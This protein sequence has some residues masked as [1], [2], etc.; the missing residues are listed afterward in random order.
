[1][2]DFSLSITHW[3]RQN[4]RTLPWRSTSNPYF[5]W[6]SEIILQQ[7]RV[8]Q[9]M[10]YYLKFIQNYPDV[11]ALANAPEMEVL[12]DWQGLGYYSRARN[13]HYSAKLIVDQFNGEFPKTFEEILQ[14]KGV[15]KYTAAAIASFAYNE[16][17]A[18]VDGNVYR[19]LSRV[20]DI[21]T[22][23]DIRKG[24]LFFQELADTLIPDKNP[25]EHNQAMMEMGA[26]IC[27]PSPNCTAC[28]IDHLCLAKERG[29]ISIRPVKSKRI[30]VRNRYFIY[31]IYDNG[32]SIVVEKRTEKDIW[33]HLYQFPLKEVDNLEQ[34][35]NTHTYSKASHFSSIITH[36]LSHQKI[37]VRFIHF[38]SLPSKFEEKWEKI[39]REQLQDYPLPRLI[40]RYLEANSQKS[41]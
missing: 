26:T 32:K 39:D 3:Y 30:K 34:L 27:T 15:G 28:P 21:E 12:N 2:S 33:Q 8:E 31:H 4:K 29:T 41:I 18:V 37:H 19:L 40:D 24:E 11:H 35:E 6:L 7:T 14:L 16:K 5:I 9:G 13:L 17:R 22:P 36:L 20:F 1:M 23:I 38:N 25:G 10:E